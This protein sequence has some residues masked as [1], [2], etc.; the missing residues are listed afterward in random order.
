MAKLLHAG[1][2]RLH[3]EDIRDICSVLAT[4]TQ[5]QSPFAGTMRAYLRQHFGADVRMPLSLDE[6]LTYVRGG[7]L[8]RITTSHN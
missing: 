8:P 3:G 4:A 7:E 5:P 2:E 6:M 1:K